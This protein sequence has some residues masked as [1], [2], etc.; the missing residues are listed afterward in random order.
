MIG[1]WHYGYQGRRP[2]R[3][4]SVADFA[5]G[6]YEVTFEE[7]DACVRDRACVSNPTP[8]DQGW[9]RARRPVINVS[10][11]DAQEYV[12]WLSAR[13][14][15]TYRLPSEAEWEYADNAPRDFETPQGRISSDSTAPVGSYRPNFFGIHDKRG[16]RAP[17]FQSPP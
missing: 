1:D 8:N 2:V 16:N 10:W 6:K 7:W 15:H 12:Q 4:V 9:G 17:R 11:R 14:G 5:I 13:T 3:R